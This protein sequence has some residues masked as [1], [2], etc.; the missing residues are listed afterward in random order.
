M[1]MTGHSQQGAG[2]LYLRV[3]T[4]CNTMVPRTHILGWCYFLDTHRNQS[5]SHLKTT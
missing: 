1:M 4:G 2:G 3:E 5:P